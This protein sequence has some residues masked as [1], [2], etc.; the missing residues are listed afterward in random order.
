MARTVAEAIVR[1][2][3]VNNGMD[4]LDYGAGTGLVTLCL[5]LHVHSIVAADSSRGMLDVL[6]QKR[7][8]AGIANVSTM[9]LD[10]ENDPPPDVCFDLI[11]SSMAMHHIAD[12]ARLVRVFSGMLKPGGWVCIADL[13]KEDGS[14]HG[15]NTGVLH[16]GFERSE[17]RGYF[18][19]AGL[20][21]ISDT[22]AFTVTK[23]VEGQGMRDFG[24]FLIAGR[25][26]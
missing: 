10:L 24:V 5:A 2:A 18:R 1:A 4:A 20:M 13:D 11:V 26:R 21:D 3:G 12:P 16:N 7:D 8:Q 15:D 6:E 9:L 22:T 17:M 25:N 23:E 14:F 19:Q